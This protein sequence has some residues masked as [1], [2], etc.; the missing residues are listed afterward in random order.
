M[1]HRH[2]IDL[3]VM[4]KPFQPYFGTSSKLPE[5]KLRLAMKGND[6]IHCSSISPLTGQ[7]LAVS[8]VLGTRLWYLEKKINEIQT[9][10]RRITA[11]IEEERN[12]NVSV[13][14]IPLPD[15]TTKFSKNNISLLFCHCIEFSF[16]ETK[17]AVQ[18][19]IYI[20]FF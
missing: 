5:I 7:Y 20:Y 11:I 17:I 3:W 1:R 13:R 16:D 15:L 6:H 9:K 19:F 8:S 18:N 10:K 2:Y 12:S 14:L 4:P